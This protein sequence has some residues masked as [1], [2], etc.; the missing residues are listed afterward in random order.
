MSIVSKETVRAGPQ[1]RWCRDALIKDL[2]K[3]KILRTP[4]A[5]LTNPAAFK[6]LPNSSDDQGDSDATSTPGN[7]APTL[8]PSPPPTSQPPYAHAL[9]PALAPARRLS[10]N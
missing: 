5:I 10:P 8:R 3:L 2:A 7:P 9:V 6:P 1:Y 4:R